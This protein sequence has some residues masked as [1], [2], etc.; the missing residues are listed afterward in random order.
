MTLDPT[1]GLRQPGT[2]RARRRLGDSSI[3]VSDVWGVDLVCEPALQEALDGLSQGPERSLVVDLSEA[4][5]MGVGPLRRIVR[6]GWGFASTE[7][8][9]P[10]PIVEKVLR[11]FGFLDGTAA[12]EGGVTAGCRSFGG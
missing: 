12:I 9:S 3:S 4:Q 2:G 6:A 1:S 8:R 11:I 7:F 10:A 5:F